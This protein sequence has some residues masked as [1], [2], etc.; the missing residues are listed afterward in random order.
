[1]LLQASYLTIALFLLAVVPMRHWSGSKE[2]RPCINELGTPMRCLCRL[3]EKITL[4]QA[5][6]GIY[7]LFDFCSRLLA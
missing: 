2:S 1:M 6:F 3:F 4:M 7:F 5:S